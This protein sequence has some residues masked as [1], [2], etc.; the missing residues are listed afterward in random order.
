MLSNENFNRYFDD[1]S[2]AIESNYTYGKSIKCNVNIC[3]E[4]NQTIA[5]YMRNS[6]RYYGKQHQY[7]Y[8]LYFDVMLELNFEENK[9]SAY[10]RDNYDDTSYLCYEGEPDYSCNS[11][12]K[13]FKSDL[14]DISPLV[15]H[16]YQ[17]F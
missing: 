5:I 2:K 1:L 6:K 7:R 15:V 4:N 14:V 10:G 9:F 11:S 13:S 3:K 16:N 17:T 8:S 12:I